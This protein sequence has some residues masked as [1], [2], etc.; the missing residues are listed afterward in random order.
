M[1]SQSFLIRMELVLQ[2]LEHKIIKL[3]PLLTK[4]F[5]TREFKKTLNDISEKISY[6]KSSIDFINCTFELV[7]K[8][9]LRISFFNFLWFYL[10]IWRVEKLFGGRGNFW[11]ASKHAL[12][13]KIMS[14]RMK[15]NK[16]NHNDYL[17]LSYSNYKHSENLQPLRKQSQQRNKH[18]SWEKGFLPDVL[19]LRLWAMTDEN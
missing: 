17:S 15:I 10:S 8:I 12:N 6:Q 14:W 19:N 5:F 9:Q 2:I 1:L 16:Q 11:K 4:S 3:F 18:L 13:M 7:N